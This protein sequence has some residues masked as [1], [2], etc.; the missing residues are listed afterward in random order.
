MS[1][2]ENRKLN[3][4]FEDPI[5][6]YYPLL[7]FYLLCGYEISVFDFNC[8]LK[9]KKW[10]R[11]LINSG[12]IKRVY[13][14]PDAKEHGAA[15]D[16]AQVIYSRFE[17]TK[18]PR[19]TEALY[20][21]P[22]T[23]NLF[24]KALA[25]EIF[26]CIYINNYLLSEEENA[27]DSRISVFIPK[28]YNLYKKLINNYGS[29]SLRYLKRVRLPIWTQPCMFVFQAYEKIKY[30][31]G[32]SLYVLASATLITLGRLGQNRLKEIP[33]FKYAIPIDM[34]LQVINSGE[35]G[36]D[37]LLDNNKITAQNTVFILNIHIDDNLLKPYIE[38]G[39]IF[40]KSNEIFDFRNL[41][42]MSLGYSFI[43]DTLVSAFKALSCW[44][45]PAC[46]IKAFSTS[47]I[48]FINWNILLR[49]VSFENY[50]YT[51]QENI[52]QSAMN[53]LIK[54]HGR[55]SWNY[56]CFM[57]GGYV[58]SVNGS[59]FNEVRHIIWSFLCFDYYV[60]MN[61]D[62]IDYYKLH[63]QKVK[64]YYSVGSIYS[65][66][67]SDKI[68]TLKKEDYILKH[69]KIPVDREYKIICF[70][71]TTFIDSE[72]CFSNFQDCLWFYRDILKL[73]NSKKNV[74]VII[75]PSKKLSWF[76][77]PLSQWASL[78]MGK[79]IA[80][81]WGTLQA[82]PRVFWVPD[83]SYKGVYVN[84]IFNSAII[85]VSDL[86]ITHCMSSPSAEA[87]GAGKKAIWYES[88]EKYR[89]IMYDN[90]PGLVVH[91]YS[92]LEERV[93]IL[94]YNTP[95]SE[96]AAYLNEHIRDKVVSHVDGLGLTRFK[97][98]LSRN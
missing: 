7:L 10:L 38:K 45:D 73:L 80:G 96:Y 70:F 3:V 77:S 44:S 76:I 43:K 22:D 93:N 9:R 89:G 63:H 16:Q 54:T 27:S 5:F 97:E 85:A 21:S 83:S 75:K 28:H 15:I 78:S 95:D 37:F 17:K 1:Y 4:F 52:K 65:E 36:F 6:F 29:Y 74:L 49:K 69:F 82:C 2:R 35:R 98:L 30:L 33:H 91:G 66:G 56:A 32:V 31:L 84:F 72:K 47:I 57:G 8:N 88:G 19:I 67:I 50:I 87:L 34:I 55:S 53:I 42:K 20:Q 86:V 51:N 58:G 79:E 12:R 41:I 23:C 46:F 62:V 59:F 68:K 64:E 60:G 61:N 92:D 39:Y 81:I 94:L 40:V 48:V 26:K 11:N 71:D 24:K 18:I 13:I 14:K 90:I 25:G